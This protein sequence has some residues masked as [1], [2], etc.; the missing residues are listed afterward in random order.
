[1]GGR[2]SPR[3]LC[4]RR[5][6]QKRQIEPSVLEVLRETTALP[7]SQVS[8]GR[9]EEEVQDETCTGVLLVLSSP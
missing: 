1:M 6:R 8:G 9:P 2:S 5:E 7:Y 3:E 4:M